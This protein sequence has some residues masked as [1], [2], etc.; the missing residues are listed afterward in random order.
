MTFE[1]ETPLGACIFRTLG[2][3]NNRTLDASTIMQNDPFVDFYY[4]LQ[5]SPHSEP[6]SIE[7]V[8]RRMAARYHPDNPRTGDGERF[9]K[10]KQAYEILSN[11]EARAAYDQ[12]YQS[13][14]KFP[15]LAF[16]GKEFNHG[17]D[18]ESNRRLGVLC[19]L[20]NRRRSDPEAAG[21]SILDLES[22][23]S[24]PREHLLFTLWYLKDRDLVRQAE[25][26]D[27]ALT[28]HG[29]DFL[30]QHLSSNPALYEMIK[31]A[32][33]GILERTAAG[34]DRSVIGV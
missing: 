1:D 3:K 22:L 12:I 24:F 31:K 32:E 18:G 8:Y 20:Y 26:T 19:L 16:D 34:S 13:R 6:E 30:E 2:R 27:F 21:L 23:M 7:R 28:S 5:I 29:A 11:S 33:A 17:I 10:L 4:L 15:L 25:S 14:S 9:L